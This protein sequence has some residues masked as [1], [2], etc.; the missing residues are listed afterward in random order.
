[1]FTKLKIASFKNEIGAEKLIM[2]SVFISLLKIK[3]FILK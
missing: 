1:M 3:I 2:K